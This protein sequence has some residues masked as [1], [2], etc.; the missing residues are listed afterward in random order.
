MQHIRHLGKDRKLQ[1]LLSS[2]ESHTLQVKKNIYLHLCGSI[3]SQQLNTKVAAVIQQRFLALY[4]KKTPSAK[5]IVNTPFEILRAIGLSNAKV[6]YVYNVCDFFI[7]NNVTDARLHKMED[8]SVIA[9]LTQIKG[10]GRW[11]AEMILMFGLGREDVFAA[12]DL[13]IQQAMTKLYKLD[14]SD[15]KQ[16]K[17][18]MISI[19]DKWRPY[20]TYACRYLWNW[21]D[22]G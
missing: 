21:K 22:N 20:R 12:D 18:Q 15:K 9:F 10:V 11:T 13:G 3:M 5:D 2:Q 7:E 17:Q 16:L 4:G 14:P 1:K 6:Q 8:E 19:S